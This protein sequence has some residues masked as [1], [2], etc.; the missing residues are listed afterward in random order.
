MRPCWGRLL[1]L[2]DRSGNRGADA[3]GRETC[4]LAIE[5]RADAIV[6]ESNYGG[7]MTSQVIHQAWQELQREQRTENMLMPAV[8]PVTAKRG[9]RLRAEPIAQLYEQGR[10]HHV[11]EWPTLEQQMATWVAGMDSPDRMDAAVHALTEL[12]NTQGNGAVSNG[13]RDARLTGRR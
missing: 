7:D 8:L 5:L 9:K 13:Y 1:L 4:L 12:A 3:W 11:G 6:V 10:V 2:D